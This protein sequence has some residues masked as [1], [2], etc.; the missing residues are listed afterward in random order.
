MV[1]NFAR[2]AD[3]LDFAL[4]EHR[5]AVGHGERFL[6]VMGDKHDGEPQAFMQIADIQ[7]HA[8][9]QL[10]VQRTQRLVHQHH[11]RLEH[12]RPRQC[13]PLLLAAG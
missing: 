8:F 7:L 5:N 11:F 6:L 3:L 10:F 1:V 12:Q 2:G 9:A 4:V 13:H